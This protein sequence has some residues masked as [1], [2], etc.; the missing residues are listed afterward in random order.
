MKNIINTAW[1][2]TCKVKKSGDFIVNGTTTIPNDP[3]NR[4]CANVL[5]W[6]E[7]GNTPEPEFTD[8]EL[9]TEEKAQAEICI[10]G[11]AEDVRKT[12]VKNPTPLKIA[13]W[14]R[15]LKVA[16]NARDGFDL[17]KDEI[18]RTKL[19]ISLRNRGETFE[20]FNAK[21]LA[22]DKKL[23]DGDSI[24]EG[25]ESSS[26]RTLK[27]CT[28]RKQVQDLLEELTTKAEVYKVKLKGL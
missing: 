20:E 21:V 26:L 22:N 4:D 19:E 28:N 1:I 24:I 23:C 13:G 10:L 3:T 12:L 17:T 16:E 6:I 15:K 8:A 14:A 27:S 5:A 25:M 9:L 7:E 2:I 18:H 11:F